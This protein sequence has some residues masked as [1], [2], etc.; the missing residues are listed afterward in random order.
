MTKMNSRCL[1]RAGLGLAFA[2]GATMI[3]P[4]SA[5]AGTQSCP[6]EY[7]YKY[8]GITNT[9]KDATG[10]NAVYGQAGLHVSITIVQGKSVTGTIGGAV[11]GEVSAIVAGAKADVSSSIALS[12]TSSVSYTGSTTIPSTW[13]NGGFLHVGGYTKKMTWYY[14]NTTPTCG[15]HINRSG[16]ANLPTS[17]P[18]YWTTRA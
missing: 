4:L 18:A 1:A 17:I 13:T 8:G 9:F 11:S 3:A 2:V 6:V 10:V 14:A 7:Y 15:E 16:P 12:K 5:S